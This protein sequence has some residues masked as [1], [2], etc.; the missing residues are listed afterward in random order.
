MTHILTFNNSINKSGMSGCTVASTL[1]QE[2]NNNKK[3]FDITI[4]E[5]GRGIGG[6]MSTRHTLD[7]DGN[8]KHQFDHGC[9]YISP[10]KTKEFQNELNRWKQKGWVKPWDAK[11]ATVGY[12]D[13]GNEKIHYKKDEERLVGYPRMN[14]ICQGLVD[15]STK[16]DGEDSSTIEVVTQIRAAATH[17]P[18]LND[19]NAH[20]DDTKMWLLKPAKAKKNS[21]EALGEYDWL[22]CTDRTSARGNKRDLMDANVHPFPE[23]ANKHLGDVPSCTTMIVLDK[24]LPIKADGLKFD[25][26]SNQKLMR[27]QFGILGW[28]ARDSLKPGRSTSNGEECWVLQSNVREGRRLLGQRNMEG[29][30][31]N[32]IRSVIRSTM[33]KDFKKS[34][35]LLMSMSNCTSTDKMPKVIE[36]IGHR[37]GAAFP[38][39]FEKGGKENMFLNM[40][41]HVD[42]DNQFIACGDYFSKYSGSVEG[43]WLSGRA[44]V[45]HLIEH[46]NT[47][48]D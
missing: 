6:R 37:W 9:Q 20:T 7:D 2:S 28:M 27:E 23:R 26:D 18:S 25:Y 48:Q 17:I 47:D 22:I 21:Q 44:A 36:S 46:L 30:R 16:S 45:N 40:D 43:A 15:Y 8:I 32:N 29:K 35:P 34:I 41:C 5:G 10:A 1:L 11:I 14:A 38:Y 13:D 33:V 19:D 39:H 4:Y 24:P 31:L 12:D 3:K 42:M